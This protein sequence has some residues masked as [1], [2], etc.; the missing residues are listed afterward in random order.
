MPEVSPDIDISIAYFVT[1]HGYGHATRAAAVMGALAQEV[2][3]V[4]F[5]VFTTAPK[6]LFENQQ[7]FRYRYHRKKTDVGLIQ[8]TPFDVDLEAT[9]AELSRFLPFEAG[10]VAKTASY[11]RKIDCRM[12]ISDI[13]PLGIYI[14]N[15]AGI[16]AALVENFTWDWIY[17]HYHTRQSRLE[18]FSQ[19]IGDINETAKIRIQVAPYCNHRPGALKT[20]PVCRPFSA[21]RKQVRADLGMSASESMVLISLGGLGQPS[22]LQLPLPGEKNVI[23]VIPGGSQKPQRS[24]NVIRLPSNPGHAHPDLVNAADTVIGKIGYSTLTEV[25]QAGV[26]FGYLA[27]TDFRESAVLKEF[28]ERNIPSVALDKEKYAAGSWGP[29]LETLLRLKRVKR[30]PVDGARQVA[31]HI[32]NYLVKFA[33]R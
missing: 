24:K 11:L 15:Q 5:E 23:F 8:S 25:Y 14:A 13:A 1:D 4:C 31:R 28:I 12:V 3:G 9:I 26:P 6:W 32:V 18:G 29:D 7:V 17:E 20:N 21:Q 16:P 10:K 27:R 33:L 19:Y 30:D 22:Q 2:P